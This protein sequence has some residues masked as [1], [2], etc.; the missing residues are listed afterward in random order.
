MKLENMA[1][2]IEQAGYDFR[3]RCEKEEQEYYTIEYLKI[4]KDILHLDLVD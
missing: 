4:E 1:D 3:I 2:A